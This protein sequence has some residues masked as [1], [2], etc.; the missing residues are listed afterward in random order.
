[1][2][3]IV[4][5]N[6]N[7]RIGAWVNYKMSGTNPL[8]T[9]HLDLYFSELLLLLYNSINRH[10]GISHKNRRHGKLGLQYNSICYITSRIGCVLL[11]GINKYRCRRDR[12]KLSNNYC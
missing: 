3:I 10:A 7:T 1:M 2:S 5:S 6:H 8:V 9:H 4:P 12:G 11:K